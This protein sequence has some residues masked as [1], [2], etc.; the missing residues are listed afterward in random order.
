MASFENLIT[1]MTHTYPHGS[2]D[3]RLD[4]KIAQLSEEQAKALLKEAA[5][6][7]TALTAAISAITGTDKLHVVDKFQ[8]LTNEEP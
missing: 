8:Q 4:V 5:T 2:P 7:F 1:T 6:L 3:Q